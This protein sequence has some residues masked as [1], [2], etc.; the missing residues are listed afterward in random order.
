MP[1]SDKLLAN[2]TSDRDAFKSSASYGGKELSRPAALRQSVKDRR[3]RVDERLKQLD[4]VMAGGA[5]WANDMA[6]E[7]KSLAA[8][9]ASAKL[10]SQF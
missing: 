9:G 8:K 7:G 10:L 4:E 2:A 5:G 1:H 6:N 3:E